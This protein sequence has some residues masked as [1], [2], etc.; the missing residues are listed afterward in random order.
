MKAGL[1]PA[2][3]GTTDDPVFSAC[4]LVSPTELHFGGWD[5]VGGTVADAVQRHAVAPNLAWL[6]DV[7]PL[8][9]VTA[10]PGI[11]AGLDIPREAVHNQ[12]LA[13]RLVSESVD[14][15]VRDIDAV[16]QEGGVS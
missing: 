16:R 6:S 10:M 5:F 1:I 11:R 2:Q 3:C 12:Y 14:Q 15:V 13:R 4:E 9:N 7:L 8:L